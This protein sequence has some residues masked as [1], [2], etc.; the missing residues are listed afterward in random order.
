MS[1]NKEQSVI[2]KSLF[3]VVRTIAAR[4]KK[5]TE[6]NVEA[7]I[8]GTVVGELGKDV[9]KLGRSN[10]NIKF[11]LEDKLGELSEELQDAKDALKEAYVDVDV[12]RIDSNS[13]RKEYLNTYLRGLGDAQKAVKNIEEAIENATDKAGDE[14]KAN[15][16]QIADIKEMLDAITKG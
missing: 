8:G 16:V 14:T 13:A 15:D 6:A 7:F 1:E 4:F 5:G 10:S 9:K 2:S 3:A 12:T 11:N